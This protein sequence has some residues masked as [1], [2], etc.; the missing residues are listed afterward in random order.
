MPLS[1]ETIGSAVNQYRRE[2]DC[3]EKLCKFVATKCEREIIRANALRAGVTSRAKTPNKVLGKLQKKYMH[4]EGLNTVADALG[5][6]SDLAGVRI[7]TYLEADRDRV[8][9]EITKL[10]D[11]PNGGLAVIEKK[12]KSGTLYRA[13]HCQVALKE[14]DLEE[15]NDNLK[16]L[17]CE[18]QVCSLL[19]HVWNELEHDLVYKPTTG[20]LS[21]RE[22]ESLSILGN[23][24][25]SGD[26]VIK[27]LFDANAERVKGAQQDEVAFQDEY[28][29]VAR[30]RDA[31]PDRKEFA[32]NAGQLFEDLVNLKYDTKAKIRSGFLTEG[33]A[34][35]SAALLEQLRQYMLQQNDVTVQIEPD[36]SDALLVLLLDAYLDEVLNLHPTGRGRGR[37]PRIAS[38]ATR[39][40]LMKDQHQGGT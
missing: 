9:Q 39:F 32:R 3:Y 2:F 22:N 35:R 25:L 1:D 7:S 17:T 40:K 5:R 21:H 13:T 24:T 14:E 12:D 23:L 34:G 38:F 11:G 20:E 19:A 37:P 6:V 28:D 18:I 31:F 33:Y 36:S 30:M 29:F 10:F 16:G 4:E 27:Q 15:P 8:V 26:V